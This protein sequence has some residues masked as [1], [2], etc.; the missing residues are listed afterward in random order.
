MIDALSLAARVTA[1]TGL[2]FSGRESKAPSGERQVILCPEGHQPAQTFQLVM[3]QGWR[4]IEVS[5]DQ[6]TF[7]G[8][9]ISAMGAADAGGRLAFQAVLGSCSAEDASV[10]LRVNGSA[11]QA[12]DDTIW[13]EPWQTF[14]FT[15]RKGQL[16]L[17]AQDAAH[18][19]TLIVKWLSRAA[20]ALVALLPLEE[21]A[22]EAATD[23]PGL[24]EGASVRVSVNK[25]ERDRRN[26]AAALAI[27]GFACKA[28]GAL[29]T[30]MYGSAASDFIEVHHVTPVSQLG[31]GYVIDPRKDLVPLCPNCHGV[32]HRR[33][34][35]YDLAELR[36]MLA[37]NA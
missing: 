19:D 3:K 6:G 15:I 26:R 34:P 35:P 14:T 10:T 23:E 16:P 32:A 2:P 30:D 21:A 9:L 13:D 7:S 4:S 11:R 29:L 33:S 31:S 12:S 25:Y 8:D 28:C 27:H 17:G 24:P 5:F 36:E 22:V 1:E 20:A 37:R 18:D